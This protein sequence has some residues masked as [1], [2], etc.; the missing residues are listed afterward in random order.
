MKNVNK[1]KKIF[2]LILFIILLILFI[3]VGSKDYSNLDKDEH[4]IF[5]QEFKEVPDENVFIYANSSKIYNVMQ[6]MENK[7][8]FFGFKQNEF[9]GHYAKILNEAAIVNGVDEI[10]YYDFYKDR[11]ENNGT[12]ESIVL[13]LKNHLNKNDIGK[14]DLVAPSMVV[15]K[16]KKIIYYDEETA[17]INGLI[18]PGDYWTDYNSELKKKT[19]SY[20]F[21]DFKKGDLNGK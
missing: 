10:L 8:I 12:Y 14:V 1:T 3:M 19:L 16:N 21:K 13:F 18:T 9:S 6:Q 4:K 11:E 20:V 5:S 7:I 2:L 15:I 17:Y